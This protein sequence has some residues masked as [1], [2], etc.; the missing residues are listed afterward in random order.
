MFKTFEERQAD[1]KQVM[2]RFVRVG[3]LRSAPTLPTSEERLD[4]LPGDQ[5]SVEQ[6][7]AAVGSLVKTGSFEVVVSPPTRL[8][9]ELTTDTQF[10]YG[11]EYVEAAA[12]IPGSRTLRVATVREAGRLIAY[13]IAHQRKAGNS[14]DIID[15][16]RDSTRSAGI[17]TLVQCGTVALTVGLGHVI[18]DALLRASPRPV[19][20]D[21]T[22]PS[23]RYIF[24][25]LGFIKRVGQ[26]NPCLLDLLGSR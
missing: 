5:W 1:R 26:V 19:A 20:V 3:E 22:N 13:G 24:K 15:V 11:Q 17:F 2:P 9:P 12:K 21:A 4:G 14:I 23:S 8:L 6:F 25:S 7:E 16:D 18:V 10:K